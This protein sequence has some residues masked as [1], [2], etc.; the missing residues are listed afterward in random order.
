MK[1]S[2]PDNHEA[3]TNQRQKNFCLSEVKPQLAPL[4]PWTIRRTHT[5]TS[6]W[7][8]SSVDSLSL[9]DA[10]RFVSLLPR[11]MLS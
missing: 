7:L 8:I 3:K 1:E 5:I 4:P 10:S 2:D 6:S 9:Q 11:V